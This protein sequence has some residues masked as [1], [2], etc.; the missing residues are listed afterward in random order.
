[1][2]TTTRIRPVSRKCTCSVHAA[3][4]GLKD[5]DSLIV[6]WD[7]ARQVILKHNLVGDARG[8]GGGAHV[9]YRARETWRA[10]G[11]V[12]WGQ[13]LNGGHARRTI[14]GG[15]RICLSKTNGKGENEKSIHSKI[16]LT[17]CS[18]LLCEAHHISS[19]WARHAKRVG[20]ARRGQLE[21][22]DNTRGKES[23]K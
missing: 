8:R 2:K 21:K 10:D 1:M 14:V 7:G 19:R 13:V 9:A 4:A 18:K 17:Y 16:Q 12:K 6:K 23:E 22:P 11:G 15:T 20:H 3:P 5:V